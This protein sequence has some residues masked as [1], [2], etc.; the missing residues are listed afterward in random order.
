MVYLKRS[1]N[2][3]VKEDHVLIW[4]KGS[5]IDLV[6]KILW[7]SS[8]VIS[9]LF[10]WFYPTHYEMNCADCARNYVIMDAYVIIEFS[11][12]KPQ[13][14]LSCVKTYSDKSN[15]TGEVLDLDRCHFILHSPI[16]ISSTHKFPMISL[17]EKRYFIR[18]SKP[19]VLLLQGL[20][21]ESWQL[22]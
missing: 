5:F 7:W 21:F 16:L 19:H 11:A 10:D 6:K 14:V 9:Y 22:R 8:Q 3:L 12:Q 17:H 4:L 2:G 18:S 13:R 1:Y 15:D 20:H